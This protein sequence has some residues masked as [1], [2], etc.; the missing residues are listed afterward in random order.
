M[1]EVTEGDN[2]LDLLEYAISFSKVVEQTWVRMIGRKAARSPKTVAATSPVRYDESTQQG[3]ERQFLLQKRYN[4]NA[5]ISCCNG[6]C[7]LV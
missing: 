7:C 4:Q 2:A 1:I 6:M 5:Q 3:P